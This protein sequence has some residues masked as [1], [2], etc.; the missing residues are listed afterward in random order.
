MFAFN[1][2]TFSMYMMTSTEPYASRFP[3]DFALAYFRDQVFAR[4]VLFELHTELGRVSMLRSQALC[5]IASSC[6]TT[7]DGNDL[8]EFMR[9]VL[10]QKLS[11]REIDLAAELKMLGLAI[12]ENLPASAWWKT[13]PKEPQ[14][15]IERDLNEED[16]PVTPTTEQRNRMKK[17]WMRLYEKGLISEE[18]LETLER[19]YEVV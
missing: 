18:Y 16:I 4:G 13:F 8:A 6:G 14:I 19:D 17:Q 7:V 5:R 1:M 9:A 3:S 10:D 2:F 15:A 12:T 11:R